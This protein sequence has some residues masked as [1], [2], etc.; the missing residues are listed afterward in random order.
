MFDVLWREFEILKRIVIFA[1]AQI[2]FL[3]T[4]K[5][6]LQ[7]KSSNCLSSAFTIYWNESKTQRHSQW[8]HLTALHP[9]QLEVQLGVSKYLDRHLQCELRLKQFALLIDLRHLWKRPLFRSRTAGI[10]RFKPQCRRRRQMVILDAAQN[11]VELFPEVVVEP[12]V[13]QR[14]RA[15]C[16]KS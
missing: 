11:F 3:C 4:R 14:V 5:I 12:T 6:N 1:R 15:R 9:I 13:E 7:V 10:H 2:R 8:T 16:C